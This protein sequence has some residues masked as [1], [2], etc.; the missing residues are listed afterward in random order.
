MSYI[1]LDLN[2][3]NKIANPDLADW[4]RKEINLA[5]KEMPGLMAIRRKYSFDFFHLL[6][7]P[8]LFH[9][10]N[11]HPIRPVGKKTLHGR[12]DVRLLHPQLWRVGYLLLCLA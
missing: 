6:P 10:P 11:R 9:P 5:E 2:L 7:L 4:G 12:R 1:E 8:D 3:K